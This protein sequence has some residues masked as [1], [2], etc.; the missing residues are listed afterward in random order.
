M[1][2]EYEPNFRNEVLTNLG[3]PKSEKL[4]KWHLMPAA[5]QTVTWRPTQN[6]LSSAWEEAEKAQSYWSGSGVV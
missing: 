4:I 3:S 1:Y 5:T 6:A 2:L